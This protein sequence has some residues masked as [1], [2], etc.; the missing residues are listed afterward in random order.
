MGGVARAAARLV[1]WLPDYWDTV[2]TVATRRP[3]R[4]AEES[5]CFGWVPTCYW[6]PCNTT[7]MQL[8]AWAL[9]A[10]WRM[11]VTR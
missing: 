3:N 1:L 9:L 11:H 7:H 2:N 5:V 4:G 6:P 10:R 8:H